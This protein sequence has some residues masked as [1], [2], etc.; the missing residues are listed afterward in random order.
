M[1][2][3][4]SLLT[5]QRISEKCLAFLNEHQLAA[6]PINYSVVYHYCANKVPELSKKI[7]KQLASK[8]GID[9]VFLEALFLEYFSNNEELTNELIQPFEETLNNTIEK[10]QVQVSNDKQ[11]VANLEKADKVLA[12]S[13]NQ[14]S[15]TNLMQF[16]NNVVSKS[17]ERHQTLSDELSDACQQINQLKNQLEQTQQEALLDAL[18]GLYNRRGCEQ[19]LSEL[20]EEIHSSLVIDIDHFKKVNDSFGHFIG[21]KVIQK[22]ASTIQNHLIEDDFAVRYGGEEFIVVMAN[23]NKSYAKAI[24]ENIRTSVTELR[25]MQRKTNTYLPPISVSIGIAEKHKDDHWQAVFENADS[26][27][28][29]AKSEGRNKCVIA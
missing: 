27:L 23:K 20:S 6:T 22:V 7:D 24:A 13:N 29:K 18:T 5:A 1:N 17:S 19:K 28:Y 26:A 16:L 15:L 12:K 2:T 10:L 14:D 4:D 25:L 11:V 3:Q 8:K 21:D 9:A